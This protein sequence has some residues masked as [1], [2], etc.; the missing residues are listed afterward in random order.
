[1]LLNFACAGCVY[2][3]APKEQFKTETQELFSNLAGSRAE[4]KEVSLSLSQS[5]GGLSSQLIDPEFAGW[6]E[7][8]PVKVVLL[9]WAVVEGKMQRDSLSLFV[10]GYW[11]GGKLILHLSWAD[12]KNDLSAEGKSFPDACA[13]EYPFFEK[14]KPPCLG[15][16]EAG[17]PV[18]IWR[19]SADACESEAVKEHI[20][21]AQVGVGQL[22]SL[23][24]E[25]ASTVTPFKNAKSEFACGSCF[26]QG[27]W[28]VTMLIETGAGS[29][30][31]GQP[32]G[33]PVAFA[34]WDGQNGDSGGQKFVSSWIRLQIPEPCRD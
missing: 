30:A 26:N 5:H 24:S 32:D 16:G 17:N 7:I 10:K 18:R 19:W 34:V 15:M 11:L 1:M 33:L 21:Q 2:G 23:I 3:N 25:G 27:R 14:K 31:L 13:L 9:R 29:R 20:C 22:E 4:D 12:Q 28:A 6:L 8:K